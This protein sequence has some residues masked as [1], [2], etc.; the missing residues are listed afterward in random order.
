M[1]VSDV[2]TPQSYHY[3][4][5]LPRASSEVQKTTA[6]TVLTWCLHS[7]IMVWIDTDILLLHAKR[8]LAVVHCLQLV[9]VIQIW[10]TP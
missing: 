7:D 6:R 10:P 2:R 9:M 8:I 4:L 5:H 3:S 1:M